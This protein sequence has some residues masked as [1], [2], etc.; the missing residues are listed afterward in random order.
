MDSSS[1][2]LPG[3]QIDGVSFASGTLRIHFSRAYIIKSMTGSVERTRW[4]QAGDLVIENAELNSDELPAGPLVCA[5]GDVSENIYT[6]RD[7]IPVPLESRGS[8]GCKLKFENRAEVLEAR[9]DAVRLELRDVA[10]YI[11]HIIPA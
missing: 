5:G 2:N 1:I 8:V 9:G 4:W 10:K 7:M 11:E 3:S 6:Y